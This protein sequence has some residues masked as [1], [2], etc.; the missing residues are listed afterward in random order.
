MSQLYWPGDKADTEVRVGRRERPR[1]DA[2]G[3]FYVRR[4][5]EAE[6]VS[7]TIQASDFQTSEVHD[8]VKQPT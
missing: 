7:K 4:R 2:A 5:V 3:A 6:S 1:E 8:P